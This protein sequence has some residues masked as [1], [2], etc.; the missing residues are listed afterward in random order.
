MKKDITLGAP[1]PDMTPVPNEMTEA[2]KSIADL[3]AAHAGALASA[4]ALGLVGV[5]GDLTSGEAAW[6]RREL[7]QLSAHSFGNTDPGTRA[8]LERADALRDYIRVP[9]VEGE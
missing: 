7:V 4:C 1:S 3:D 5:Q 2:E 6:E 8:I 9:A